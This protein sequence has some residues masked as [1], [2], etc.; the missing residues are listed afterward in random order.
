MT[1]PRRFFMQKGRGDRR[2]PRERAAGMRRD[3]VPE[4]CS[5]LGDRCRCGARG[6]CSA[7]GSEAAEL[8]EHEHEK[9]LLERHLRELFERAFLN[10]S[11]GPARR[12]KLSEEVPF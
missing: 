7:C 2:G 5:C 1:E 8:T 9:A 3:E 10:R 11:S 6:R 12:G 4:E